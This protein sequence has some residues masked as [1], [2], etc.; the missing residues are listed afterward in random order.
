MFGEYG[1]SCALNADDREESDLPSLSGNRS[2]KGK[3]RLISRLT[4]YLLDIDFCN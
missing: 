2:R 4:V 3:W 1:G